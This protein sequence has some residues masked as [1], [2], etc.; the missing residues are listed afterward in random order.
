M[1]TYEGAV[2]LIY[3]LHLCCP[4]RI[5]VVGKMSWNQEELEDHVK[6]QAVMET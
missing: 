1:Q 4:Y 5:Q 6:K 3:D 2:N